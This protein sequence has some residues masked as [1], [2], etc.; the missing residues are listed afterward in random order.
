MDEIEFG[1]AYQNARVLI[2]HSTDPEIGPVNVRNAM[3]V[4]LSM[5]DSVNQRITERQEAEEDE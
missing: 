1:R 2:G 4:L 5:I 3:L